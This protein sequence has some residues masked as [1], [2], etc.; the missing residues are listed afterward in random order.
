MLETL[1]QYA[2]EQLAADGDE[3]QLHER[4]RLW[5]V[6]L[7]ERGER[8]IWRAD[9]VLWVRLLTNDQDNLRAALRWTLRSATDP[10]PGLRGLERASVASGTRGVT[11]VKVL[12]GYGICWRC[13]AY[14]RAHPDGPSDDGP[15]LSDGCPGEQ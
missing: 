7:A 5:C 9:Q 8:E 3:R 10:D 15:R 12:A 14:R 1:R 2:A 11:F 6:D 13:P 4:H